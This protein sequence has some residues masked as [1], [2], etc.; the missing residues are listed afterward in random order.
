[1]FSYRKGELRELISKREGNKPLISREG[2]SW[3]LGL[4]SHRKGE[5][6]EFIS[7]RELIRP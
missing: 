5:V 4:F 2:I 6:R 3:G 7:Q 1:M